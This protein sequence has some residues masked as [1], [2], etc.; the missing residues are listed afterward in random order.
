MSQYQYLCIYI[1]AA[2]SDGKQGASRAVAGPQ[3]KDEENARKREKRE[4]LARAR[5]RAKKR[6]KSATAR[7]VTRVR[8]RGPKASSFYTCPDKLSALRA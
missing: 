5:D 1:E 3:G 6:Q 7:C 8:S 4:T 2:A